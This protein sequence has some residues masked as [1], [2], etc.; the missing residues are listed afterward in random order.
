MAIETIGLR[1]VYGR[2]VAVEGISLTVTAGEVFGF[3][4]PNG[5][6]KST[7][8]KMLT[9]LV[10]PTAGEARLFGRPIGDLAIKRRI[11]FLPEHFRFPDWLTAA[12]LLDFHG[13][14]AKMPEAERRRRAHETLRLVG[15]SD[16]AN[17]TLRTF[18]K[19][20]LQR[21]GLAQALL[22]DPDLIFLDEP[23]SALDP[24]GRREVRDIIRCLKQAGKTV[25]L[26]SHLLSEIELVCDRVVIIDRGRIVREGDLATLLDRH[27]LEVRVSEASPALL[28]ELSTRYEVLSHREGLLLLNIPGPDEIPQIAEMIIK[29]GARLYGLSSRKRSLEDL[30]A[31]VVEGGSD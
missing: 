6:G 4:G 25:F 27:E 12:E 26:N 1:K 20:M 8:V 21:I 24:L 10:Y 3:L 16:R 17:D 30:F 14:L 7:M 29:A 5:A 18:S 13:K 2:K 15:L 11:G 31:E 9:G 19:G 23:T 22:A 28:Q